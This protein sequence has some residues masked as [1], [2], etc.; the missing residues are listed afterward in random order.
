MMRLCAAAARRPELPNAQTSD[1]EFLD[2]ETLDP[3]TLHSERPD[4]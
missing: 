3:A 1:F 4:R 2:I